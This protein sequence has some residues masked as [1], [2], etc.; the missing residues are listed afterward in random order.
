MDDFVAEPFEAG[1]D[2]EPRSLA[3]IERRGLSRPGD[4]EVLSLTTGLA[5]AN[6]FRRAS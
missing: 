3:C 2:P 5:R 4:R 1:A 6:T